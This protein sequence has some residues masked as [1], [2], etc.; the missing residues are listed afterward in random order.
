M[1]VTRNGVF[2]NLHISLV[3]LEAAAC[4]L[5][6]HAP[7]PNSRIGE[8]LALAGMTYVYFAE[9]YCP[10]VPFSERQPDGSIQYGQPLA[11]NAILDRAISRFDSAVTVTDTQS[12]PADPVAR[13]RVLDLPPVGKGRAPR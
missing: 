2:C 1:N 11:T 6:Q 5:Q 3:A 10:A 12:S 9:N 4:A 8:M 7:T 13:L